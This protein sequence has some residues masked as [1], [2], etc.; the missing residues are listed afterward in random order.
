M[1][2]STVQLPSIPIIDNN[3]LIPLTSITFQQVDANNW[4]YTAN[5]NNSCSS[6][7]SSG[8]N[9]INDSSK[10]N[11]HNTLPDNGPIQQQ[12]I[13]DKS[14]FSVIED[15]MKEI[16]NDVPLEQENEQ[17]LTQKSE[18]QLSL[19][20]EEDEDDDLLHTFLNIESYFEKKLIVLVR[21]EDML[22][23]IKNPDYRNVKR[24]LEVWERISGKLR[25]SVKQC[26][27][28]WKALRDQFIREHKRL[29]VQKNAELMP[30]WRH[31]DALMFLQQFVKTRIT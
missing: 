18:Q 26:R 16:H 17:Q 7:N 1:E 25:K 4:T 3:D 23:N 20:S 19:P 28:K 12:Q 27:A 10:Q 21:Q 6:S 11:L 24:K 15:C 22:Y 2:N 14:L 29:G 30:K 9:H 5:C 13:T 31:Y 8:N